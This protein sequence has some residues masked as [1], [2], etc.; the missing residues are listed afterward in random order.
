MWTRALLKENGKV[1]F[2]RNYWTCV[3]VSVILGLLVGN[4]S[5]FNFN[6]DKDLWTNYGKPG[7][8]YISPEAIANS[9]G[10]E[11]LQYMMILLPIIMFA[12]VLGVVIAIV[13]ATFVSNVFEVGGAR[14]YIENREHQTEV[15]RVLW[16]F[17]NNYMEIVKTQF[18]RQLYIF[19]WSLLFIIPGIVKSLSYSMIP[20]L[21]A[22]NPSLSKERAFDISMQMMDGHKMDLF[23]LGLSFIGWHFLNASTFGLLGIFYVNPYMHATY[24]EF[25]SALKAEALQ[26]GIANADELPGVSI[27][28]QIIF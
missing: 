17:K 14:Y 28:T 7:N 5:G 27:E 2:K 3:L 15:S 16:G 20:Y 18:L 10:G 13:V 26:R 22:E 6:V 23:V 11:A 4:G 8:S 21:L 25:Y 12:L 19:G 9:L 24:A 1:A